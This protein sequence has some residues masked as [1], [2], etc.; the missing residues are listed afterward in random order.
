VIH[1]CKG[2]II[3]TRRPHP[4]FP[5]FEC[6]WREQQKARISTQIPFELD[7]FPPFELFIV[8]F[9]LDEFPFCPNPHFWYL[10]LYSERYVLLYLLLQRRLPYRTALASLDHR[11][12]Q[13]I[14]PVFSASANAVTPDGTVSPPSCELY[15]SSNTI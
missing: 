2:V 15:L 13:N 12:S 6:C 14:P 5:L 3:Y 9:P 8:S 10:D 7:T 11:R 4:K 1:E